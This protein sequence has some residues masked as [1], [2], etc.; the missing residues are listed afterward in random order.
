MPGPRID[1]HG[2][3]DWIT[4]CRMLLWWGILLPLFLAVLL[5]SYRQLLIP[6]SLVV[7]EGVSLWYKVL[8]SAPLLFLFRLVALA[9]GLVLLLICF[10]LPTMR[11]GSHGVSWNHVFE[12]QLADLAGEFAGD[13]V[14]YIVQEES[15]RWQA[16]QYWIHRGVP[17]LEAGAIFQEYLF[18][19]HENFIETRICVSVVRDNKRYVLTHPVFPFLKRELEEDKDPGHKISAG[20]RLLTEEWLVELETD[21]PGGYSP[22]D[23]GFLAALTGIFLRSLTEA[24]RRELS[25][26]IPGFFLTEMNNGFEDGI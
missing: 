22:L 2:F 1:L 8:N 20:F 15:K 10:F 21:V 16:M 6:S 25:L 24:D 5:I 17:G 4:R 14:N 3:N 7:D 23:H 19:L 12:E 18:A 9:F 11:V 13:E 26:R